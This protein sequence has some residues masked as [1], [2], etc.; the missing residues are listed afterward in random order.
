MLMKHILVWLLAFVTGCATTPAGATGR[1]DYAGLDRLV[2]QLMAED[3]VPGL[4]L[5]IVDGDQVI[6]R[7][8]GVKA[9]GRH[10][11]VTN[12]TGF[13]YGSTNKAFVAL[14]VAILQKEGRLSL[15]DPIRKH[16]PEFSVDDPY[17]TQNAT[18]LDALS[19]RTG[20]LRA[21]FM[22]FGDPQASFDTIL[23]RMRHLPQA[24]SFR[25]GFEYSNLMYAV[26]EHIVA[27]ISGMSF[28]RF[29]HERIFKPLQMHDSTMQ[30]SIYERMD[31]LAL[32]HAE[33]ARGVVAIPRKER[34]FGYQSSTAPFIGSAED[35]ARW[36]Q[37]LTGTGAGA[38]APISRSGLE[39]TWRRITPLPDK[40]G[41]LQSILFKDA[42]EVSYAQGWFVADYANTRT[43]THL[44]GA[45]GMA[46]LVSV[47][48][49]RR[50]G[51]V[52]LSNLGGSM[53]RSVIRNWVFDKA[54]QRSPG[55]SLVEYQ[56]WKLATLAPGYA[57]GKRINQAR[58]TSVIPKVPISAY[59]GR[60]ENI[61][62][63]SIVISEGPTGLSAKINSRPLV[64]LEHWQGSNFRLI[65]ELENYN[66][67][68]P[69]LLLFGSGLDGKPDRFVL[70][71]GGERIEFRKVP[72]K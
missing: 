46:A 70:D 20:L 28:D 7:S 1:T 30:R 36:L 15:D 49:E 66:W 47:M 40:G 55:N 39:A 27:R 38:D 9:V 58:D 3:G 51:I 57:F 71:G 25:G 50:V 54:L 68:V 59:A 48:P 31:N 45:D 16:M 8:Y 62:S 13:G 42:G 33:S 65:W 12:R 11:K 18:I 53:V 14:A 67:P 10:D 63:G 2:T 43:I 64:Q 60:Y 17:V 6:V 22:W 41:A 23:G 61:T 69:T 32:P 24:H 19:H 5:A 26:V 37:F 52:V 34:A 56:K 4:S 29:M 44:G 72:A 21:D 35:G